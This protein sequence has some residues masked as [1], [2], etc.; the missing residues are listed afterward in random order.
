MLASKQN[1]NR[2]STLAIFCYCTSTPW[3][4]ISRIP[5]FRTSM[6]VC[7]PSLGLVETDFCLAGVTL[8]S[9]H[10]TNR[11]LPPFLSVLQTLIPA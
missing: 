10:M 8:L 9:L 1:V 6:S 2:I 4:R 3:P 7:Q 11:G 5:E